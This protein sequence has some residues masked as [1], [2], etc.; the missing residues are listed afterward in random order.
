MI[1]NDFLTSDTLATFWGLVLGTAL[2]VQFTKPLFKKY[3]NDGVVRIYTFAIALILTSAFS[4]DTLNFQSII[5]AILNAMTISIG[6]MGAYEIVVD[7]F[8]EKERR[9][10]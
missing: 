4:L 3:C 6:A 10:D 2:V 5:L 7:P 9:D 8:A 1:I